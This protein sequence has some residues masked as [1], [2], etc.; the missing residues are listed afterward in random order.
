MLRPR[1]ETIKK[2]KYKFGAIKKAIAKNPGSND[3]VYEVI[4]LDLIDPAE[5]D[6]RKKLQ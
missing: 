4:Y 5:P 6:S 1:L 2:K 3:T